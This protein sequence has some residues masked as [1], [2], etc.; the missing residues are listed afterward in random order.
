MSVTC[1]TCGIEKPSKD[2]RQDK[3]SRICKS[4]EY[5][6]NKRWIENNS[7]RRKKQRSKA[8]R[9]AYYGHCT[10]FQ[11]YEDMWDDITHCQCCNAEFGGSR[12]LTKCM[13]HVDAGPNSY[14]RGIIC[15]NCNIGIGCLGDNLDGVFNAIHYLDRG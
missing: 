12:R 8:N 13:D 11:E 2:Y 5:E 4:C 1:N 3:K 9:K 10:N 7:E 6:S 14:V 15:G